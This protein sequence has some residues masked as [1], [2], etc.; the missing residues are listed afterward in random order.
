MGLPGST[1]TGFV[2]VDWTLAKYYTNFHQFSGFSGNFLV[3]G[4]NFPEKSASHN[5]LSDFGSLFL[6]SNL[7]SSN[8]RS[9]RRW[10]GIEFQT[11]S[12]F[13]PVS[14]PEFSG[15][16]S[17]SRGIF[18]KV[19]HFCSFLATWGT[20]LP[21]TFSMLLTPVWTQVIEFVEKFF[22]SGKIQICSHQCSIYKLN[23]GC[24]TNTPNVT[25]RH[26]PSLGEGVQ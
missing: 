1:A 26:P 9:L 10:W 17:F 6:L 20:F 11:L 2:A 18:L 24:Q 3:L 22:P 7:S 5:V 16:S 15:N 19:T 25:S 4:E 12:A 8:P 14:F 23:R 13:F 21:Q